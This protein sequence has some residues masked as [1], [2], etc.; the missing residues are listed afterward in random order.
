[1][2]KASHFIRSMGHRGSHMNENSVVLGNQSALPE[3]SRD[4]LSKMIEIAKDKDLSDADKSALISYAQKKFLN[5][6]RMAYI[7]LITIVMSLL[8]VFVAAFIDGLSVCPKDE[9]CSG[10]LD[11]IKDNQVL[12]A[13]IEGFLTSI[14]AAYYGVSAWRPAS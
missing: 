12:I 3:S 6:R 1:M 14:V 8:V 9:V 2:D 13:S 4:P 11:N 5:R 7:A 10:I